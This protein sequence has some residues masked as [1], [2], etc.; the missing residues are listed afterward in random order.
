MSAPICPY[1]GNPSELV[2]GGVVYPR[3]PD[4]ASKWFWRCA[5]CK[6]WVGCHPTTQRPLGRLA[7]AELRSAKS[8]VHSVFDL[9]WKGGEMSRGNAYA[10]LAD[11]LGIPVS[12][13][14]VGM[15]DLERCKLAIDVCR[16]RRRQ[17][18]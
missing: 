6:A 9:I 14:H 12:E 18:R 11:Q 5:P 13:C 10:W 15:F 3:R 7:N 1:C 17:S 2:S 8:V 4:L 16:E